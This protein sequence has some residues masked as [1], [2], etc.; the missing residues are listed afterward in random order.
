MQSAGPQWG[1]VQYGLID[2]RVHTSRYSD[3]VG[4]EENTS[5]MAQISPEPTYDHDLARRVVDYLQSGDT[6]LFPFTAKMDPVKRAA[7]N[8]DLRDGLSDLLDSGS[9]RK[10]SATGFLM[11]DQRLH[12]IIQEWRDAGGGWPPGADP[13]A[14]DTPLAAF[15]DFDEVD[16]SELGD[17]LV[18]DELASWRVPR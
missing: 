5:T 4:R 13:D 15:D 18:E 3:T 10:T 2:R 16:D 7:F 9:A 17:A 6:R 1:R 12:E 8:R 14:V 11:R